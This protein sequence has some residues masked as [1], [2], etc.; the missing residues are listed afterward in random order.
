MLLRVHSYWYTKKA[1]FASASWRWI[2]I[3]WQMLLGFESA[4]VV[5]GRSGGLALCPIAVWEK[6][7][8]GEMAQQ[9]RWPANFGRPA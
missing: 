1:V 8:H 3:G 9:A 2:R 4:G 7:S 6:R 5:R